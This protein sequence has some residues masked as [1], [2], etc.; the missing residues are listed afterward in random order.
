MF[1]ASTDREFDGNV[2]NAVE[3]AKSLWSEMKA[4]GVVNLCASVTGPNTIR[5]MTLWRSKEE[6][7]ANLGKITDTAG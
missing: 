3:N 4:S 2:E 7:K 5:K 1:A 6:V